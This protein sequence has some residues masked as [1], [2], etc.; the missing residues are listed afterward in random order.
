MSD[1]YNDK[2]FDQA[3]L[4]AGLLLRITALENLLI[5][6]HIISEDELK[7]YFQELAIKISHIINAVPEHALPIYGPSKMLT[8]ENGNIDYHNDQ[9]T[10]FNDLLKEFNL[11]LNKMKISKGN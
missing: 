3:K 5:A 8:D 4:I 9:E 2:D 6:K 7:I 10:E 11:N 1:G